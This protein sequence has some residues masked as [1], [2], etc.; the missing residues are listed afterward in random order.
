MNPSVPVLKKESFIICRG[1]YCTPCHVEALRKEKYTA[2]IAGDILTITHF[3]N[4]GS[5]HK[6]CDTLT[7]DFPKYSFMVKKAV[8]ELR[9]EEL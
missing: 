2:E 8:I 4:A 6:V 5:A 9:V 1:I 7:I 3:P